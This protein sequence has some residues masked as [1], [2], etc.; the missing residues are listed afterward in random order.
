[1][2]AHINFTGNAA[3]AAL[4]SNNMA[5]PPSGANPSGTMTNNV[6]KAQ[7]VTTTKS[8]HTT[9]SAPISTPAQ[10]SSNNCHKNSSHFSTSNNSLSGTCDSTKSQKTTKENKTNDVAALSTNANGEGAATKLSC[11]T[12]SP[13]GNVM[14][15]EVHCKLMIYC[16]VH[17]YFKICKQIVFNDNVH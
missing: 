9:F 8:I 15:S 1:M 17:K 4:A 7:V 16:T 13:P 12:S 11:A 14:K 6:T 2:H 5:A 10:S 3:T